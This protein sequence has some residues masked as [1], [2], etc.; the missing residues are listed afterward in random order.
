MLANLAYKRVRPRDAIPRPE[1]CMRPW[2]VMQQ[3][4]ENVYY[5]YIHFSSRLQTPAI[6]AENG[7]SRL[8]TV[9]ARSDAL[10]FVCAPEQNSRASVTHNTRGPQTRQ[11]RGRY[12]TIRGLRRGWLPRIGTYRASAEKSSQADGGDNTGPCK[13]LQGKGTEYAG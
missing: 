9:I 10:A 6:P 1:N 5:I 11:Y 4:K 2:Q 13:N 8:D 7:R 12:E 3:A